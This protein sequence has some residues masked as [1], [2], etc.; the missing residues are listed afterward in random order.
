MNS[1]LKAQELMPTV[2]LGTRKSELAMV[3]TRMVLKELKE[4]YPD[5]NFEIIGITTTGDKILD[6]ALSKIGS[7]SLFTKELEIALQDSTVDLVVHSLKDLPTTLPEGMALGSVMERE[8]PRDAVVMSPKYKGFKLETLPAG[9]VVGTS[10][11]RRSAQLK[12]K[13]PNLEFQDVVIKK[14]II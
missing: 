14:E 5:I 2:I 9:S 7:K 10:S 8:D 6:K 3:Q 12:R 13:F 11:V 1:A 4:I